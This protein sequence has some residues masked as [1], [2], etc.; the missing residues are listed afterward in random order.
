MAVTIA[1]TSGIANAPTDLA[2]VLVALQAHVATVGAEAQQAQAAATA[3]ELQL[4]NFL[5]V[6]APLPPRL[7]LRFGQLLHPTH[8]L[9]Q[10]LW[11]LSLC[12]ARP[13]V[14]AYATCGPGAPICTTRGLDFTLRLTP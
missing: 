2:D 9:L 6:A 3:L 7:V 4:A 13:T 1:T 12:H 11:R 5:G 10:V 14:P 8:L